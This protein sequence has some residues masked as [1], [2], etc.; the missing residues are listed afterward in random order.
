[1][2]RL[3]AALVVVALCAGCSGDDAEPSEGARIVTT[4]TQAPVAGDLD[5]D[6]PDGAYAVPLPS[7]GFGLALPN[8]F[9]ATRL[10]ADALGRL[11]DA[12]TQAGIEVFVAAAKTAAAAG[13]DFYAAGVDGQDRVAELKLRRSDGLGLTTDDLRARAQA[14]VD[15]AGVDEFEIAELVV[16]GTDAVLLTFELAGTDAETGDVIDTSV[17]QYFVA[18]ADRLFSVIITAE[19]AVAREQLAEL[20]ERS[21][22]LAG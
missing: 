7:L 10:D 18:G 2:R 16:A 14:A 20:F 6:T 17:A 9:Q 12:E 11:E 19:A 22:T 15:E 13:A 1:M 21:F 5:I 8:G 3:A 4:S